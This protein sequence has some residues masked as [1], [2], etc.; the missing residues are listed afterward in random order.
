MKKKNLLSNKKWK[1]K[2]C[3]AMGKKWQTSWKANR[4]GRQHVYEYHQG[5][6]EI[7]LIKKKQLSV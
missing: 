2:V 6:G 7:D 4:A 1:C 5:N 3:G